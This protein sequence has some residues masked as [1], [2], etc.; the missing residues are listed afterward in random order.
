MSDKT[1]AERVIE[2]VMALTP[3]EQAIIVKAL[4]NNLAKG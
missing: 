3:E 2:Q 4:L 1:A